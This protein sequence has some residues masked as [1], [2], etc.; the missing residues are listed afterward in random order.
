MA[1]CGLLAVLVSSCSSGSSKPLVS[2]GAPPLIVCG[3]TLW[4][5][6]A[7]APISYYSR[8]GD[9]RLS[10]SLIAGQ[11]HPIVVSFS[12]SCAA[13]G[14]GVTL[15]PYGQ[16]SVGAKVYARDGSIVAIAVRGLRPGVATIVATTV[17]GD[18]IRILVTVS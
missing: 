1:L 11:L 16:L 2:S 14:H 4:S 18:S 10:E 9:Y 3:Q 8:P 12:H 15:E 7:G 17:H 6:G 13:G 5:G